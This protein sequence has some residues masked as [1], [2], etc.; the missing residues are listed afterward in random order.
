[1]DNSLYNKYK[2]IDLSEPLVNLYVELITQDETNQKVF[3]YIGQKMSDVMRPNSETKIGATVSDMVQDIKVVRPVLRKKDGKYEN[4][5]EHMERKRA[6]RIVQS[7]LMTGLCYYELVGKS[8]VFYLTNRGIQVM[9]RIVELKKASANS[10]NK[11]AN[12]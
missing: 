10:S 3:L 5:L 2:G 12:K 7:L 1:M 4:V 11:T 8:K 9:K 6:E